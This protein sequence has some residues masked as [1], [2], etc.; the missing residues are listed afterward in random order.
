M[1]PSY[2][3]PWLAGGRLETVKL[4]I[5]PSESVADSGSIAVAPA[6]DGMLEVVTFVATGG[7]FVTGM[8]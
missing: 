6:E 5:E 1:A 2:S 7:R 3:T 4:T 8:V